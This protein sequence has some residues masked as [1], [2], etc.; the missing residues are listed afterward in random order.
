[1]PRYFL[2]VAYRGTA[3][4]GWQRQKNAIA[5]QNVLEEALSRLLRT[6]VALKGASRTDAGAHARQNFAH[7]D[8]PESLP[9]KIVLNL[10]RLL[11]ESVLVRAIYEVP[12]YAHARFSVRTRLYAYCVHFHRDPF[13]DSFSYRYP[14]PSSIQIDNGR[15]VSGAPPI[16]M[17]ALGQAT[18]LLLTHTDFSAF[19]KTNGKETSPHCRIVYAR[20]FWFAARRQL[21]F[22]I[23]GNRFLRGMIRALVGTLLRVATGYY[24]LED[25]HQILIHSQKSKVDFTPPGHGLYLLRIRY[26]FAFV[27]TKYTERGRISGEAICPSSTPALFSSGSG[28]FY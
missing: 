27:W 13:R 19:A 1:M 28:G 23:E 4:H 7:F 20:W 24:S 9:E 21:I 25:F 26:P 18:R 11:P 15:A 2:E 16:D 8:F 12:Q 5:V 10:N 3:F 6:S 22:L 17:H 14:L